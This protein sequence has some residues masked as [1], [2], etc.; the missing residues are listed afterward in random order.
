MI[1]F[2]KFIDNIAWVSAWLFCI[3]GFMLSYE[4][5][6][7]YFFLSPTIW[8]AELSQISLIYGTLL[9]MPWA[10]KS[11]KHIQINLVINKLSKNYKKFINILIM[12][13]LLIFSSYVMVYGFDIFYDSLIRGRTTGSLLNLPSWIAEL[14]VPFCFLLLLIQSLIEIIKLL[15]NIEPPESDH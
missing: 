9:A 8:A 15:K 14:S 1:Y 3:S 5:I 4:V 10:L 2:E 11:R 13:V 7:R 6:A 12:I